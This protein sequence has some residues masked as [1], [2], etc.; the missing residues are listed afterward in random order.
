MTPAANISP[1]PNI[2]DIPK[3]MA[4]GIIADLQIQTK[5]HWPHDIKSECDLKCF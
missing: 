2:V 1:L 3:H 4:R 5:H